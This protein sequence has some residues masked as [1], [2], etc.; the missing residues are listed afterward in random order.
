MSGSGGSP[1]GLRVLIGLDL[2]S[3]KLVSATV[4]P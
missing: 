3:Q 4:C 2:V 1:L